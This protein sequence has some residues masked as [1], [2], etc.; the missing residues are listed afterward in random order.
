MSLIQ[1]FFKFFTL[2]LYLLVLMSETLF[3]LCMGRGSIK[4]LTNG[5][6]CRVDRY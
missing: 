1:V 3:L 6:S 4:L 5:P 2:H